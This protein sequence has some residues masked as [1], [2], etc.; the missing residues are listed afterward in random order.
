MEPT[1]FQLSLYKQL[2]PVLGLTATV[3]KFADETS[4]NEIRILSCPDPID[5][6]VS[7][8]S[9]LG[10][11]ELAVYN[12]DTEI[13]LSG[14][15]SFD[16]LP[17]IL[18]SVGF[19]VIKDKWKTIDGSVF[20]T[21]VEMYYPGL[22]MKHLYFTS[23]YLWQDKLE[24]FSVDGKAINFLLAIP[25]SNHELNIKNEHGA[26]ALEDLFQENEIDIFDLNRNSVV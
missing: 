26:E 19:F 16:K 2:S 13:L 21:L 14:Y 6:N 10:L 5:E 7:F 24:D 22:E 1:K 15:S 23:P 4:T 20:E 25:I 17:N 18:S 11:S 8:Y 12:N 3:V 9:T